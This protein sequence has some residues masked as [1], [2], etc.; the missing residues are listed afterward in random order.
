VRRRAWLLGGAGTAAA[1]AGLGWQL[2]R[3]PPAEPAPAAFWQTRLAQPDGGELDFGTLRG[4][5]LVLNFWATWCVPCIQEMPD[6]DRFQRSFAG[7]GWRVVGVA[8]DNPTAVREFLR[9]MP[10]GYAIGLAGFEG[11]QLSRELGNDKGGLPFT[12]VFDRSGALV[13]RRLGQT[14]LAELTAWAREM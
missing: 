8:V 9:K 13:R 6:L 12:V 1:L 7:A 11:S 4:S 5:P 2:A 3:R 10:V 14:H